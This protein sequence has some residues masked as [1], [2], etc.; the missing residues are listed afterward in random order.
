MKICFVDNFLLAQDTDGFRVE[1]QP[2]L[3]LISLIAVARAHGH[4]AVLYDPKLEFY[5]GDL[6]LGPDL[7][8]TAANRIL[9]ENPDVVGFTSLGCNF[10]C[11]LRMADEVRARKPEI[12]ILLGGPH[13][14]ILDREILERYKQFDVIVRGETELTLP[15]VLAAVEG[16]AQISE[17]DGVTFR[18]GGQIHRTPDAGPILDLDGLPEPAYDAYPV[19][20][21]NLS[22]LDVDAGRGCPFHCSFCSTA[23]FFGR[24][25]RIKSAAR[26]VRD[27]DRLHAT[28]GVH[29]FGL[30]HDLFTVNKAKIREF[31]D[32]V[33]PRR[34]TWGCSARIDCVDE[35][36]LG[37]MRK[38][39]CTSIFYG[40][41][42]GSQRLQK[43]INKNLDLALYEPIVSASVGLGMKVTASFITGYPNEV[44]ED[45]AATLDLIDHSIT[46]YLDDLHVQLHLLTPE[47]GTAMLADFADAV[48]YDGHISDFN[49]P[50]LDSRD[51]KIVAEDAAVFIC[52]RYYDAGCDRTQ[53]IAIS[54]G[55]RL[56]YGLGHVLLRA[57][58]ESYG[59]TLCEMFEECGRLAVRMQA[60]YMTKIV[61]FVTERWGEQHPLYDICKY[62][63]ALMQLQ[64]DGAERTTSIKMEAPIRLA[65]CIVPIGYTRNGFEL[66]HELYGGA[67]LNDN[68]AYGWHIIVADKELRSHTLFV[69][70]KS[71]Y[72]L[73]HALK[74]PGTAAELAVR[75]DSADIAERL[76]PLTLMG[77]LVSCDG[78]REAS[79][80]EPRIRELWE[81]VPAS[82]TW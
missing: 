51:A 34:Y 38:A 79:Q 68:H 61:A 45:Q 47:P 57:M 16:R 55:F 41:E 2:H 29:H 52:Q 67:T 9:A 23:S 36:L 13:A 56:L 30:N 62:L 40:V 65:R 8:A 59:G 35:Q 10:A 20:E 44:L 7:Y 22:W 71:L 5:R 43:I 48:K 70:E 81:G 33:A 37:E 60:P 78:T 49:F 80:G 14:S 69:V 12:P 1:L 46:S 53:N 64:P 73:L 31:C 75:F 27:L 76:W 3:G 11:T 50:P 28:Y 63:A 58:K 24:R 17:C 21:M 26:L 42:T 82:R 77:A 25:Y 72:D 39:G 74:T 32:A 19:A 4:Q 6:K 18:S 66:G 54:E 15:D